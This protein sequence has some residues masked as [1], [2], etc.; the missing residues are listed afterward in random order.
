LGEA[1]ALLDAL[2]HVSQGIAIIRDSH[3]SRKA[4][5]YTLWQQL[6]LIENTILSPLLRKGS[7]LS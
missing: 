2:T 5:T 4:D 6:L 7:V 1:S 3:E